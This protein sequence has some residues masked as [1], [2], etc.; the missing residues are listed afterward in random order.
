MSKLEESSQGPPLRCMSW[1][2][3]FVTRMLTRDL[4]A[5]ANLLVI[6]HRVYNND[7]NKSCGEFSSDSEASEIDSE[8]RPTR[9]Q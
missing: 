2:K 3:S 4:F 7:F 9:R 6:V 5:A 1:A 8:V